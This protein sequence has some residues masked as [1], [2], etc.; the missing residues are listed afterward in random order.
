MVIG[1]VPLQLVTVTLTV[2]APAGEVA[3][4]C[5]GLTVVTPVAGTP[6]KLRHQSGRFFRL[7]EL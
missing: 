7:T 3:V 6:P 4:I 2:P 1:L 5:V